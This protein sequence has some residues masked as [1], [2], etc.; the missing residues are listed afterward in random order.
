MLYEWRLYESVY[1]RALP[2]Y[3]GK[4]PLGKQISC[5]HI[6]LEQYPQVGDYLE[7]E[8]N[9]DRKSLLKVERIVHSEGHPTRLDCVDD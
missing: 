4:I 8:L 1:V 7:V 6:E 9:P 2:G 3:S 5:G